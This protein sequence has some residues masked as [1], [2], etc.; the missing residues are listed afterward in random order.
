MATDSPKNTDAIHSR[1]K[2]ALSLMRAFKGGK[3][4]MKPYL[5]K[6]ERESDTGYQ[7][8]Q[9]NATLFNQT[10]K[11]IKTANGLIFRK[12]VTLDEEINPL[13]V[14]RLDDIDDADTSL[15]DFAKDVEDTA[16]WDGLALILVDVPR[17][18]GE[19]VNLAQQRAL[20]LIP[21]FTKYE[22]G[23]VLNRK[24]V[25]GKLTQITLQETVTE[26]EGQFK[27]K[28]VTQER[29]LFIG[30]G[31]VYRDNEVVYEWSNNLS[32]IPLVPIY[33]N[34]EGFF[35]AS[36]RYLDLAEL[37]LEHYNFK[38]QLRKTLFIASNP[39]PI[40]W[41]APDD[42]KTVNIGVD[43]AL[44][45]DR[46]G[47]GNFEWREFAGTSVDKL[48]EEIKKIEERMLAI[49]ISL[50]TE[51]EQ[52]AREATINAVGETSDLASMASS[53]EKGLNI[54][55]SYW[56]DLM[57]VVTTGKITVN[58]DFTGATLSPQE[59]KMYLDMYQAG[60]ITLAQ[61]WDEMEMREYIKPFDRDVVKSELEASNQETDLLNV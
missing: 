8:R 1:R 19:V 41:S 49:G 27:E 31:K 39:I 37:N 13:F 18:D 24:V 6:W 9:K 48:Q 43:K 56:C 26:Y 51:K 32:Y 28:S 54:A 58:K 23:Q 61:F 16:L 11:T 59:A 44:V 35:D 22:F 29:V 14:E 25:D 3:E 36:P 33:S 57:G 15:N 20:G 17:H 10:K 45:F 42:N 12:D 30:G 38:S 34:K 5:A 46:V 21:Y 52:T 4:T 7:D 50:L 47:E 53:L 2:D 40:I 60:T 55:Y